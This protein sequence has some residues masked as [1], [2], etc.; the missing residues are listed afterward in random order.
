MSLLNDADLR[1]NRLPTWAT[2][3]LMH[4]DDP[5]IKL[6]EREYLATLESIQQKEKRAQY[7]VRQ[8]AYRQEELAKLSKE[9]E[10]GAV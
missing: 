8:I 4:G 5:I 1:G 3:S 9:S 10:T 7:I 6:K 2:G